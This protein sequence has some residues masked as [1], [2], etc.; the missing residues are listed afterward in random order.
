MEDSWFFWPTSVLQHTFF[1]LGLFGFFWGTFF[2]FFFLVYFRFPVSQPLPFFPI[3]FYNTNTHSL[4]AY[5]MTVFDKNFH[6]K[7]V[8]CLEFNHMHVF[9]SFF[10]FHFLHFFIYFFHFGRRLKGFTKLFNYRSLFSAQYYDKK[11]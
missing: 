2:I 1:F 8:A 11:F 9:I 3:S 7:C 5:M 4:T 10:I 6:Q